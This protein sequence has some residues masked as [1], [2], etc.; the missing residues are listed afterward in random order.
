MPFE[1][2]ANACVPI[3]HHSE[4]STVHVSHVRTI[5]SCLP[6]T[7]HCAAAAP[8][9]TTVVHWALGA[10]GIVGGAASDGGSSHAHPR[11]HSR[12]PPFTVAQRTSSPSQEPWPCVQ[13]STVTGFVHMPTPL[14]LDGKQ[15]L[16]GHT[17]SEFTIFVQGS[18]TWGRQFAHAGGSQMVGL[19]THRK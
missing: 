4:K 7:S 19:H 11:M 17:P 2:H 8:E 13:T 3:V 6:L 5:G 10:W 12:A 16:P 9:P 18:G 14:G 1:W 15:M